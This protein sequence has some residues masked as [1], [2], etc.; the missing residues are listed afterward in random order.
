[1]K[2]DELIMRE[3]RDLAEL[4]E[5]ILNARRH[6]ESYAA[7]IRTPAAPSIEPGVTKKQNLDFVLIQ[8]DRVHRYLL[9]LEATYL[10]LANDVAEEEEFADFRE[11]A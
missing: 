8:L 6:C 7:E 10:S 9:Q 5:K 1:M 11:S 2:P 3:C 4:R